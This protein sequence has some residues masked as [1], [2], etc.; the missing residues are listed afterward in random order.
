MSYGPGLGGVGSRA[1]SSLGAGRTWHRGAG[2]RREG[3]S[4][5]TEESFPLPVQP[6]GEATTLSVC[7]F[8][9]LL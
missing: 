8:R 1:V 5:R 7:Y 4:G 9:L 6:S 2:A 3:S